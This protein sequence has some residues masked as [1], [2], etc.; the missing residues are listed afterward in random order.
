MFLFSHFTYSF[1]QKKIKKASE[2]IITGSALEKV[3][4][5]FYWE[6]MIG[7]SLTNHW[8]GMY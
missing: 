2:V 1:S 6:E 4:F 8:L 5:I 3:Y 7:N